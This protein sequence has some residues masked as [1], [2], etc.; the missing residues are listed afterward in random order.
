MK[1]VVDAK[2]PGK[3]YTADQVAL[4]FEILTKDAK[5]SDGNIVALT[6]PLSTNDAASNEAAALAKANDF[7]AWRKQA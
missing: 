4:A 2:M 5:A 3:E 1:A 6:T 7:N